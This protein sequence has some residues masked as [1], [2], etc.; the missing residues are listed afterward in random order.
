MRVA[1]QMYVLQPRQR[2]ALVLP[3]QQRG[4]WLWAFLEHLD[5]APDSS[6]SLC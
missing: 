2:L 4:L 1:Y 6:I 5:E 3:V